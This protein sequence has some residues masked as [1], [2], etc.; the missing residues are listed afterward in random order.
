MTV[1]DF[2]LDDGLHSFPISER[3]SRSS[4]TFIFSCLFSCFSSCKVFADL[5]PRC[6]RI[7][8]ISFRRSRCNSCFTTSFPPSPSFSAICRCV[9]PS[10][11]SRC[12]SGSNFCTFSYFP[13]MKITPYVVLLFSYIG[14]VLS[15][16]RFLRFGAKRRSSFCCFDYYA[17]GTASALAF[18][19]AEAAA[20]ANITATTASNI[21]A[22]NCSVPE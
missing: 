4:S 14:G 21:S 6:L 18:F 5:R 1:Y 12:T 16:V 3:K 13:G 17:A 10:A 9:Q 8:G 22:I 19:L 2:V 11:F 15:I 7:P 20:T